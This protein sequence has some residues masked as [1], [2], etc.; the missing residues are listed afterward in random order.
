VALKIKSS[1]MGAGRCRNAEDPQSHRSD[2]DNSEA[3]EGERNSPKLHREFCRLSFNRSIFG[4][5]FKGAKQVKLGMATT[6]GC[7]RETE[8][9]T[10]GMRWEKN[11]EIAR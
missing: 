7:H 2:D 1:F 4:E 9:G 5:T 8:L 10:P 6:H 3:P 11:L